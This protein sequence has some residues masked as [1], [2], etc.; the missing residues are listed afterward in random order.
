[1]ISLE[2]YA[3]YLSQ[4]REAR[5]KQAELNS[6]EEITLSTS[7]PTNDSV[8]TRRKRLHLA[9]LSERTKV[10]DGDLLDVHRASLLVRSCFLLLHGAKALQTAPLFQLR[11]EARR[12]G[13]EAGGGGLSQFVWRPA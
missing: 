3:A 5:C 11:R 12:R 4:M 9:L 6:I 2:L 1:M 10:R 8:R 7:I 13:G